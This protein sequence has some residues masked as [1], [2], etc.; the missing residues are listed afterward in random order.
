[1]MKHVRIFSICVML[2]G[3]G[4]MTLRCSDNPAKSSGSI[5]GSVQV[6]TLQTDATGAIIGNYLS[7]IGGP[8][9]TLLKDGDA[10]SAK[11]VDASGAFSFDNVEEGSYTFRA[12]FV[13]EITSY[14]AVSTTPVT[15]ETDGVTVTADPVVIETGGPL[16]DTNFEMQAPFPN[17]N[18]EMNV[19][20]RYQNDAVRHIR[21]RVY[22]AQGN[23]VKT[24]E[25]APRQVLEYLIFWDFTDSTNTDVA[26]GTYFI[27]AESDDLPLPLYHR[28]VVRQ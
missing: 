4:M 11:E 3:I 7:S 20:I 19:N 1:M 6:A 8:L 15:I 10:K 18:N 26:A 27:V 16:S 13:N 17:P 9:I 28:G 23:P 25:D 22:D 14:Q 24:L 2:L 21:T 12:I 5:E